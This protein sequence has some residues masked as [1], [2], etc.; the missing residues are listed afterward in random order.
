MLKLS[1]LKKTVKQL[2][3]ESPSLCLWLSGGS[4]SLL[5]LHVMLD[6]KKPF[7][8]LRFEEGWNRNQQKAVDAITLKHDLQCFTYPAVSNML[9]GDGE[10]ISLMSFYAVDGY[11]GQAMLV[12][13]LVHDAKRCAF[14]INLESAKQ[15][16]APIEYDLH[17]WGTRSDDRHWIDEGRP[18][19]KTTEWSI[20]KQRFTAPLAKWHR[21]EVIEALKIYGVA[22]QMPLDEMDGG[23]IMTCFNCL[24]T[25]EKTFCPKIG[26]D[27]NGVKW[28]GQGN[29][30][31]IRKL[32][33]VQ[34]CK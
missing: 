11:G 8:I 32:L 5:L 9:V 13:D 19:L 23:N 14:D 7:G 31:T 33:E 2:F 4:D 17:I 22:W 21:A 27:I 24:Q 25:T 20:G 6:V 12:K 16:A 34:P 18:L 29:L 3:D 26:G 10:Q 28:D 15:K 1:S 30:K